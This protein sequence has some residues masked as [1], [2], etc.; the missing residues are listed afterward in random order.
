MRYRAALRTE[1]DRIHKP[2]PGLPF[3]L[4]P[5]G[6]RVSDFSGSGDVAAGIA[7]RS[8][9]VRVPRRT[10]AAI[11]LYRQRSLLASNAERLK[12]NPGCDRF[13]WGHAPRVAAIMSSAPRCPLDCP[14]PSRPPGH[15]PSPCAHATHI[16]TAAA[17]TSR[18]SMLEDYRGGRVFEVR[19]RYPSF[20]IKVYLIIVPREMN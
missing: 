13:K 20:H 19:S 1:R 15:P 11:Q 12:I 16:G 4:G 2:A 8:I 10:L 6:A 3:F 7:F 14:S 18:C 9:R 17:V 5:L